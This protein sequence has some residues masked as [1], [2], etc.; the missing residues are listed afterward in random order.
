MD[1]RVRTFVAVRLSSATQNRLHAAATKLAGDEGALHPTPAADLHL[2]LQFLGYTHQEDI[3]PIGHALDEALEEVPP[4]FASF[5][6]L[7]AFPDAARARVVW[8]GI[9]EDEGGAEVSALARTIGRVMREVGYRPEKRR[10]HPHVTIA[11][12]RRRPPE[13]FALKLAEASQLDLGGEMLSE[14]KLILSDSGQ[15]PY[16][17]IDLTTVELGG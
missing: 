2:T 4:I 10:F 1:K 3:T 13:P 9:P 11:R 14:V 6:G 15:R 12:V 16:H 5:V 8:A 7:G 17:Y